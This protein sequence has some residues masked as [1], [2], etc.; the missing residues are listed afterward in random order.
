MD[1]LVTTEW[2]ARNL[3]APDVAIVDSS[4]FLPT[5][6]RDPAAEFLDAH[7]PGARFLDISKVADRNH[8]APHMLP[9]A[10]DFA[11]AMTE[12]GVAP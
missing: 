6:G 10:G 3:D 1:D 4:A 2:L 9:S 12:L 7:I 8:P 5:D 11:R